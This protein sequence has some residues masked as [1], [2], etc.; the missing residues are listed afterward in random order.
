MKHPKHG[1]NHQNRN[2]PL[3]FEA[4]GYSEEKNLI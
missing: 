1:L 2:C 4:E 3:K